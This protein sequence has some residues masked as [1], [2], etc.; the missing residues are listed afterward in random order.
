MNEW[1]NDNH[2]KLNIKKTKIMMIKTKSDIEMN[3]FIG[4]NFNNELIKREESIK[5]LGLIIDEKMNWDKHIESIKNKLISLCAAIFRIRKYL[6][7]KILWKIYNAHFLSHI[8]YMNQIWSN[9]KEQNI[10]DLQRI[11][12]KIIKLIE[13]KPRLTSSE[14]L[15]RNRMNIRDINKYN[16][17]VLI[18]KIKLKKMK[19]NFKMN[20][21]QNVQRNYLRNLMNYRP[22]FFR[23]EKCKNSIMSYGLNLYNK[24]PLEIKN[25]TNLR[26]FKI[27]MKECIKKL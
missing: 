12:N 2:L 26:L 8:N 21:V 20:I 19:F 9:T 5:Y 7:K 1:F 17:I 15:Y 24:I 27:K 13:R 11:Q 6:P 14:S 18:Q 22:N 16:F 10:N 25:I 4:V 3:H 23:K